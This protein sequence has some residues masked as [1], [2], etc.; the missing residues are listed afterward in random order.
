MLITAITD[1]AETTTTAG[2]AIF[3]DNGFFDCTELFELGTQR[4]I[5]GVPRKATNE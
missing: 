1:E 3:D 4:F 2:V 5:I